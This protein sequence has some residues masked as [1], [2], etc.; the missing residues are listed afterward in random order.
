M[1]AAASTSLWMG[2][3]NIYIVCLTCDIRFK[4]ISYSAIVTRAQPAQEP[5][6]AVACNQTAW[7]ISIPPKTVENAS[8]FLLS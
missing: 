4:N 2:D 1:M 7:K 6:D 3:V 5:T 8:I